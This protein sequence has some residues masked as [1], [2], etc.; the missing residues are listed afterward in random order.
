LW[1]LWFPSTLLRATLFPFDFAQGSAFN[2]Y[3]LTFSLIS[4]RYSIQLLICRLYGGD[5]GDL[6]NK[7][8]HIPINGHAMAVSLRNTI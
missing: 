2:L 6:S 3:P 4:L 5:I 7:Y 1:N 8:G